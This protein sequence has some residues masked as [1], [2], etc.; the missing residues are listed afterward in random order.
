MHVRGEQ[1]AGEKEKNGMIWFKTGLIATI[2]LMA[3]A[4]GDSPGTVVGDWF[5]CKGPQG[6][7]SVLDNDGTQFRA[8]GSWSDLW[9]DGG[10]DSAA[11]EPGESYCEGK[12]ERRGTYSLR[13][14]TLKL[15][16]SDERLYTNVV[17]DNDELKL[18]DEGQPETWKRVSPSRVSG[19]CPTT[20]LPPTRRPRSARSRGI[21]SPSAQGSSA[22][23][24]A[25][26]PSGPG[27]L[28]DEPGERPGT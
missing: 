6:N 5:F 2:G 23:W 25:E 24:A 9:S 4:C 11:T 19:P 7:C 18:L 3:V 28:V 14:G 15:E 12:D 26:P 21:R 27:P 22:D 8:D 17:Q 1:T 10:K 16:G 13:D 20:P